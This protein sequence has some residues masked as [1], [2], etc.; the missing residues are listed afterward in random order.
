MKKYVTTVLTFL[1][2]SSQAVKAEVGFGITGALHMFEASGTE[3]TRRCPGKVLGHAP[4][5][6]PA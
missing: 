2:I 4:F 6:M 5:F 3:T 1:F